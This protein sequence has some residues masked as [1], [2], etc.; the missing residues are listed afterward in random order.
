MSQFER[1]LTVLTQAMFNFLYISGGKAI[2]KMLVRLLLSPQ[3]LG[4]PSPKQ[5]LS[6]ITLKKVLWITE[7]EDIARCVTLC[8]MQ[9]DR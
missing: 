2:T 3:G 9:G 4:N 6:L 8:L 5:D 1:N 7:L